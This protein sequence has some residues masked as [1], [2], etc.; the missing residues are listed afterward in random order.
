MRDFRDAKAMAQSLRQALNA[1]N[2]TISHSDSLELIAKSFGYDNWNILVAK[3]DDRPAAALGEQINDPPT[4]HCSFCGK[5]QDEVKRIIAGAGGFICDE[6]TRDVSAHFDDEELLGAMKTADRDG[7]DPYQP[8]AAILSRWGE[9][10]LD[11]CRQRQEENPASPFAGPSDLIADL[12]AQRAL[13]R[14]GTFFDLPKQIRLRFSCR[15]AYRVIVATAEGVCHILDQFAG[16]YLCAP[17]L[18]SRFPTEGGEIQSL[19]V[20]RG[21][22][23]GGKWNPWHHIPAAT[24]SDDI[25]WSGP[26]DA[27]S[28]EGHGP[29]N[30]GN[31]PSADKRL[32][33]NKQAQRSSN[34][35]QASFIGAVK[36]RRL[37]LPEMGFR[38]IYEVQIGL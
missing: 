5:P 19:L 32:V 25:P 35:A 1:R 17:N 7:I 8:V 27:P 16:R 29:A 9:G 30:P 34:R 4:I 37:D 36:R 15:P 26:I 14:A 10:Q 6:C 24:E 11:Q 38:G 21:V 23:A 28:P 13:E 22:S 18:N 2:I 12:L 3:I 20:E 33:C 31:L